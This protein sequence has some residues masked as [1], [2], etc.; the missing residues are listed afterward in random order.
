MDPCEDKCGKSMGSEFVTTLP[1][2]PKWTL[3]AN[4][5]AT[6]FHPLAIVALR[7]PQAYRPLVMGGGNPSRLHLFTSFENAARYEK[8]GKIAVVAG[9][10]FKVI[11]RDQSDNLVTS[12]G[13]P[14]ADDSAL[15]NML[16]TQVPEVTIL[17]GFIIAKGLLTVFP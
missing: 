11:I 12:K 2:S 16:K 17:F 4:S 13:M 15:Q 7:I 14:V 5:T 6:V 9:Q 10:S 8:M 1:I 3:F